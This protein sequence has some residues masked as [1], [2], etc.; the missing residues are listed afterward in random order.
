MNDLFD[1]NTQ[2]VPPYEPRFVPARLMPALLDCWRM[3][4]VGTTNWRPTRHE[5]KLRA[6]EMFLQA[7]PGATTPT[8][9]YK[10]LDC[11]V[12]QGR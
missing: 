7:H 5:R 4:A 10:D 9:A 3:T 8:G 12:E 11:S 2:V 6:C 1:D